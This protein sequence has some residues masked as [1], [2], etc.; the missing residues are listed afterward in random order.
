MSSGSQARS[1][2]D[3]PWV[4][5]SKASLRRLTVTLSETPDAACRARS[6]LLAFSE[7][8]SDAGS[9][10]FSVTKG[11]LAYR[12]GVSIRT[13]QRVLPDLEKAGVLRVERADSGIKTAS[14]YTLL[15]VSIEIGQE[16]LSTSHN[17]S[18]IGPAAGGGHLADRVEEGS[19]EQSERSVSRAR[20]EPL[21]L[22]ETAIIDISAVLATS[23]KAI[24]EAL[25]TFNEIKAN[26]PKDPITPEAFKGWLRSSTAG[27]AV[28]RRHNLDPKASIPEPIRWKEWL[29]AKRPSSPLA[30]GGDREA[31]D[32]AQL[33]PESRTMITEGMKSEPL[34]SNREPS[35]SQL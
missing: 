13:V 1:T 24:T 21:M 30:K 4:W 19:K 15:A 16:V 9:N 11:L 10:T 2:R 8:A 29:N 18:T 32:W 28:L 6:V 22:S 26:Y 5:L 3:G 7:L 34:N 33:G 12:A 20:R 27:K 14:T 23:T 17:G 25:T 31:N 35:P